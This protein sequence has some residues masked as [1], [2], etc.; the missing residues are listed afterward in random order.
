LPS[1]GDLSVLFRVLNAALKE[2]EMKYRILDPELFGTSFNL[3][4]VAD[5]DVYPESWILISSIPDFGSNNNNKKKRGNK[6]LT[7]NFTKFNLI[8]FLKRYRTKY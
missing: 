4:S 3:H 5:S 6:F 1:L 8:L 2:P 7:I